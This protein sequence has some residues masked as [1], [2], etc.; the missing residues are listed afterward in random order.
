MLKNN[1]SQ[2][3]QCQN[4]WDSETIWDKNIIYCEF[5]FFHKSR[6]NFLVLEELAEINE[7]EIQ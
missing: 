6:K 5:D 4:F 2:Q 1:Y 7:M 3:L